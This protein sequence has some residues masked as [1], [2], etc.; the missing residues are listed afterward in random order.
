VKVTNGRWIPVFTYYQL[1]FTIMAEIKI[2]K[3]NYNWVWIIVAIVVIGL[4][5]WLFTSNNDDT[6]RDER[7]VPQQEQT[8]PRD[9]QTLPRDTVVAPNQP[10]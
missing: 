6:R 2:E 8:T 1:K 10:G 9:Q 3:K 5:I 4:L 7:V